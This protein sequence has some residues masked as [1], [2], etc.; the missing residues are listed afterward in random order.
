MLLFEL[1][2]EKIVKTVNTKNYGD[3][4]V[5]AI[6][7]FV[8]NDINITDIMELIL[9]ETYKLKHATISRENQSTFSLL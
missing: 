9:R 5:Q 2:P 1:E 4:F 8:I 3:G 6:L 7:W